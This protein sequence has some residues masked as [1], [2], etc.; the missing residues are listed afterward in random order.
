MAKI[1]FSLYVFVMKNRKPL[2]IF[3][4]YLTHDIEFRIIYIWDFITVLSRLYSR[5]LLW[6]TLTCE[7]Y[8]SKFCLNS[9]LLIK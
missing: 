9:I 8:Q 1:R 2:T 7:K 3:F 6:I 4:K 5:V